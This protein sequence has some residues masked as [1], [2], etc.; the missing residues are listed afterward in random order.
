[1]GTQAATQSA[2][3]GQLDVAQSLHTAPTPQESQNPSHAVAHC[4]VA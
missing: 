2:H 3:I 1:M 4:P